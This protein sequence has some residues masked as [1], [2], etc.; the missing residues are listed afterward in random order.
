[1]IE[2]ESMSRLKP[3]TAWR[4]IVEDKRLPCKARVMALEQ[5]ARP[6]L[7]L[8]RRLLAAQS[9]P[10]KLRLLA[11]EKYTLAVTRKELTRNGA[12]PATGSN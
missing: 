10:P 5:I 12:K 6:S 11:A 4:R 1:V 9:T 7:S 8:L 3:E 2:G